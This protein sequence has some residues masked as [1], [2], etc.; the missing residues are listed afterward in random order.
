MSEGAVETTNEWSPL[1][2]IL[3]QR[4]QGN[5]VH[6]VTNKSAGQFKG[7][8]PGEEV[9]SIAQ[10]AMAKITVGRN[11]DNTICLD[12]DPLVSGHHCIILKVENSFYLQDGDGAGKSS[13]NGTYLNGRMMQDKAVKLNMG[14]EIGVGNYTLVLE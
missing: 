2:Q 7:A 5:L 11:S 14:D 4:Q 1:W 8:K 6:L 3:V 10:T 12:D 9:Q 13:T